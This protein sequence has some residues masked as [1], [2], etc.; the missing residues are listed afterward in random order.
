MRRLIG[1]VLLGGSL[2]LFACGG[3]GSDSDA[4]K[5]YKGFAK[6]MCACKD[7]TCAKAVNKKEQSW[8]MANYKSLSKDDRGKMKNT[9]QGFTKCRNKLTKPAGG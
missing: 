3:S 9:R 8:R 2:F 5:T 6:E 4:I 1:Q 7:A